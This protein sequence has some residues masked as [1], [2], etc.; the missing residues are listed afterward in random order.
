[1]TMP[2]GILAPRYGHDWYVLCSRALEA[3]ESAAALAEDYE[4]PQPGR[5]RLCSNVLFIHLA[6][7]LPCGVATGIACALAEISQ[8]STLSWGA[9]KLDFRSA[10]SISP[11]ADAAIDPVSIPS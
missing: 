3:P 1:M 5:F 7:W 10:L 11:L 2:T 8:D 6:L 9:L 4:S